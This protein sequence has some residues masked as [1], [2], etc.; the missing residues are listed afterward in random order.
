MGLFD[1]VIPQNQGQPMGSP[2]MNQPMVGQPMNQPMG[3][4]QADMS[5]GFSGGF[6]SGFSGADGFGYD[7]GFSSGYG[8]YGASQG[9]GGFDAYGQQSYGS[10]DRFGNIKYSKHEIIDALIY[11]IQ[12]TTGRVVVEQQKI[13]DTP[14]FLRHACAEAKISRLQRLSFPVYEMGIEVPFY[15][16]LACG[17]LFYPSNFM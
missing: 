3:Y 10:M 13:E 11:Q 12:C 6:S 9:Y 8:A 15:F 2:S 14:D 4:S 16:C 7:N 1:D 5:Q 17:K